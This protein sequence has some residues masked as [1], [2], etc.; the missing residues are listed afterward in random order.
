MAPGNDIRATA[1]TGANYN[2]VTN[3][4]YD[5]GGLFVNGH[6]LILDEYSLRAVFNARHFGLIGVGQQDSRVLLPAE[7]FLVLDG[8]IFNVGAGLFRGKSIWNDDRVLGARGRVGNSNFSGE[9]YAGRGVIEVW[10]EDG[11]P[12]Q[13]W[14]NFITGATLAGRRSIFNG[15][16][17]V[18]EELDRNGD[19][20]DTRLSYLLNTDSIWKRSLRLFS[21]GKFSLKRGGYEVA[22]GARKDITDEV[23]VEGRY[24]RTNRRPFFEELG[25]QLENYAEDR[26]EI[27]V[28]VRPMEELAVRASAGGGRHSA[29]SE[30]S[31]ASGYADLEVLYR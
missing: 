29:L 24:K 22:V 3:D 31:V 16:A 20:Y 19:P 15:R 13:H 30:V 25:D 18:E 14:D 6:Y 17:G 9:I 7:G 4:K 28:V 26:G 2:A 5:S 27:A 12:H 8:C 11:F 23:G 10:E 21:G 1:T